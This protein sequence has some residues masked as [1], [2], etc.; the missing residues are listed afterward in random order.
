MDTTCEIIRMKTR[1]KMV[2]N[3]GL[4]KIVEVTKHSS[5]WKSDLD[6][7]CT[8]CNTRLL[9]FTRRQGEDLNL[10]E[11]LYCCGKRR[12]KEQITISLT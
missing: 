8:D 11:H 9:Y 3:T 6:V 7:H 10:N 2:L 12:T 1:D 4:L 5:M